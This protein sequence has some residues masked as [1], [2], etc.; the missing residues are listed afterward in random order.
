MRVAL[1]YGAWLVGLPLEILII[2]T[3]LRGSF[4]RFPFLLLYCVALFLTTVIEISVNLAYY[5]G[6]RFSHSRATYYWI[7][8]AIRQALIYAVVISWIYLA[9]ANLRSRTFVR[10]SLIIGAII[11]AGVSFLVHY[12]SHALAGDKWTWMTLWVRDLDFSAAVLDLMLWA[13]LL[14]ARQRNSQ[15]LM[16]SGGLGIQFTGEAIGQSL[17]YL[18]RW[19]LSPGDIIDLLTN[20]FGLWIWWQA[21]RPAG[22]PEPPE[23]GRRLPVGRSGTGATVIPQSSTNTALRRGMST[24]SETARGQHYPGSPNLGT[25]LPDR[26]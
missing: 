4:R 9:T 11:L 14:G 24:D 13:L 8:E 10:I 7:D 6:I 21:L 19:Q 25:Q 2:A 1:Q 16:L 22:R 5:S 26:R 18:I 20:L 15:L 12:N 17:R 23:P 3:L